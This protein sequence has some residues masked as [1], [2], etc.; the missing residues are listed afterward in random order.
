M[1]IR[2]SRHALAVFPDIVVYPGPPAA[3]QPD[4]FDQ[5]ITE[6]TEKT[7]PNLEASV[8]LVVGQIPEDL[9][10]L[11]TTR[12]GNS[13]VVDWNRSSLLLQHVNLDNIEITD[14]PVRGEDVL[15]Q[16]FREAGYQLSL[17]HIS[18]PTRPY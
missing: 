3:A 7:N 8:R 4:V 17:I 11:I 18:E 16:H 9:S 6:T 10:R 1:C 13:P 15:D 2:D 14:L 5:A 12:T